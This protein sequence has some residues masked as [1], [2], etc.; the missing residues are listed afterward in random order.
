LRF[1]RQAKCGLSKPTSK[2]STDFGVAEV[3]ES[4]SRR[5]AHALLGV[6]D[7]SLCVKPPQ[8][9]VPPTGGELRRRREEKRKEKKKKGALYRGVPEYTSTIADKYVQHITQLLHFYKQFVKLTAT[10]KFDILADVNG[11]SEST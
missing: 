11:R 5:S 4:H 3:H 9:R 7:F 1:R 10:E 2:I 6:R 8:K